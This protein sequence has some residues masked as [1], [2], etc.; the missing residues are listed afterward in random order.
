MPRLL[1]AVAACLCACLSAAPA[2]ADWSGDRKADVLAVHPDGRLLMYR[3]TGA[4]T[5][6]A[7]GGQAIGTG[8]GSF[9]ALL[10]PGDW[11]GDGKPDLLARNS[12]GLLLMYRGNGRSGFLTGQGERIGS[13]WGPFTALLAPRDWNGDGKRDILART[14]DGKLLMYRGNGHGGFL[15]PTGQ[16]I[17]SG[18]QGF[19]AL[20][21]PR[22]WSGDGKSDILARDANGL[23]LMYRG[24]GRG[25]FVTGAA[26]RIGSGWQI[27]DALFAGGDFSGDGKPDIL[28]RDANGLLFMYRGNGRGGFV[29]G[30]ARADRQRLELAQ[31]PDA[32]LGPPARDPSAASARRRRRASRSPTAARGSRSPAAAHARAAA[33]RC[34]CASAAAPGAPRRACSSSSSSCAGARSG[35]TTSGRSSCG[36]G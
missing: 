13:G 12:D 1:V 24:N 9:T 15:L 11:S 33:S 18:W 32:R 20:L 21:A 26:E 34:A 35:S 30:T 2:R 36:C 5:F 22:D 17:G 27:F 31:R 7:G 29:T 25:G 28:A 16:Q 6:A 10:A 14:S 3:G 4:G 23:L 19:T 8:W